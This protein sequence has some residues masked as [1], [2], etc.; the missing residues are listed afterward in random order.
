VTERQREYQL[1]GLELPEP[2][3]RVTTLR[4]AT[5]VSVAHL[6]LPDVPGETLCR[7]AVPPDAALMDAL[8]GR[9]CSSC[10]E[11]SEWIGLT[12]RV[13]RLPL[14]AEFDPY[15]CFACTCRGRH[16]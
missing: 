16:Y 1:S 14:L 8:E 10:H 15:L 3:V 11:T 12:C 5:E 9:L 13:C 2:R 6:A 7:R 4:F